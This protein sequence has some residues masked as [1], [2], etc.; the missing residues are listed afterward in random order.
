MLIHRVTAELPAGATQQVLQPLPRPPARHSQRLSVPA[1]AQPPA[2]LLVDVEAGSG[3]NRLLLS[4]AP[5]ASSGGDGGRVSAPEL[6]VNLTLRGDDMG[7]VTTAADSW[8]VRLLLC[9]GLALR[10]HAEACKMSLLQGCLGQ[11]QKGSTSGTH[12]RK[13]MG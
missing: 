4:A 11:R 7:S 9:L 12:G 2:L 5:G 1:S 10:L 13:R 6:A 8:G 3:L